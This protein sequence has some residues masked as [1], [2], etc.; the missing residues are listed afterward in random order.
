MRPTEVS[1]SGT[2]AVTLRPDSSHLV[3]RAA[4]PELHTAVRGGQRLD[5]GG[6]APLGRLRG[7]QALQA[8][9]CV[10]GAPVGQLLRLRHDLL[11]VGVERLPHGP[12]QVPTQRWQTLCAPLPHLSVPL[13]IGCAPP[14]APTPCEH[15]PTLCERALRHCVCPYSAPIP[16][17]HAPSHRVHPSPV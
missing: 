5:G 13:H 9:G 11:V 17:E 14:C 7:G 12:V 10:G 1:I 3:V 6:A 15:A 8:G 2:I 16:C 4:G